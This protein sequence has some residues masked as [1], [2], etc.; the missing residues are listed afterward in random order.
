MKI[1][2]LY[3]NINEAFVES[4][5]DI[6]DVELDLLRKYILATHSLCFNLGY[7][8]AIND[9]ASGKKAIKKDFNMSDFNKE[10]RFSLGNIGDDKIG[11]Q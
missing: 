11:L 2:E 4:G 9:V 6:C 5:L 7:N 8:E 10:I 3:K 1:E